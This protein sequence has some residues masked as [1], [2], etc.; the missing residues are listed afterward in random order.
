MTPYILLGRKILPPESSPSP[1]HIYDRY[2]QI[3]INRT[4]GLPLVSCMQTQASQFGETTLTET[5]EGV[6]QTEGTVYAP[7]FDATIQPP[8]H[9]GVSETKRSALQASQ[10]GETTFTK[11]SEGTD[12]GEGASPQEIHATYS[13]F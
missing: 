9:E 7:E 2:R 12:Q 6:D 8:T 1:N 13:H 5:R 3:W 11:T 4:S 10:Y